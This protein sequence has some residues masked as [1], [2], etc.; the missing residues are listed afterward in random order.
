ME[1]VATKFK[2]LSSS[3]LLLLGEMYDQDTSLKLAQIDN[4]YVYEAISFDLL[5][6]NRV[7]AT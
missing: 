4:A 7:V 5:K 1:D 3:K 6:F 2:K